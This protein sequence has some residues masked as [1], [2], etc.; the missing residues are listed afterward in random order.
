[1][2]LPARTSR[3]STSKPRSVARPTSPEFLQSL[4]YILPAAGSIYL[5]RRVGDG[6][7]VTL[8]VWATEMNV[9]MNG[10]TGAGKTTTAQELDF[11]APF[12]DMA[13][14]ALDFIGTGHHG[15]RTH[16]AFLGTLLFNLEETF[17][18]ILAGATQWFLRRFAFGA[19]SWRGNNAIRID[20]LKRRR[21]PDGTLETVQEVVDRCLNVFSMRYE[22]DMNLRVRFRKTAK[23]ILAI[24]VASGR[25]ITEWSTL[26]EKGNVNYF[27]F[28]LRE[29]ETNGL[30]GDEFVQR[31]LVKLKDLWALPP[32]V[33]EA[34][35]ESFTNSMDDYDTGTALGTFFG[36]DETYDPAQAV[37]GN[38]RLFLTTD[39]PN[40]TH[41]KEAF[42]AVH[43]IN[44]ALFT[45]RRPGTGSYGLLHYVLDEADKW[46]PRSIL[47][48][49][50][51]ARNL[52][53]S[54]WLLFQ[55]MAQW[56]SAG[57]K[58]MADIRE[59]VCSLNADYR[60][61]TQSQAKE[62]YLRTHEIDPMGELHRLLTHSTSSSNT[63]TETIA[64]SWQDAISE[65]SA[66]SGNEGAS[67]SE[68]MNEDGETC[69]RSQGARQGSG[70]SATHGNSA[71]FGGSRGSSFASTV[72]KAISETIIR[73]PF[74]ERL[75]VGAQ[76]LLRRPD[77]Q[78]TWAYGGQA[79]EVDMDPP[80]KFPEDIDGVPILECYQQWHDAYWTRQATARPAFNPTITLVTAS[81]PPT[82][83][84]PT[85]STPPPTKGDARTETNATASTK[86]RGPSPE[87]S[88]ERITE[89]S[90]TSALRIVATIR[91]C[92]IQ[93]VIALLGWGYD[94][95]SRELQQLVKIAAVEQIRAF[96]P[97]GEGSVPLIFILTTTGA[98]ILAEK[99][100]AGDDLQRI[101]KNLAVFRRTIEANRPA[102][103]EHRLWSST[104]AAFLIRSL[105]DSSNATVTDVRFDRELSIPMNLSTYAIPERERL[106]IGIDIAKAVYVPDFS[107]VA[108]RKRDGKD[109][110]DIV[111]GEIE[112][113]FGE[114]DARDLGAAKA[115]KMRAITSEFSKT[116]TVGGTIYDSGSELRIVVWNRT[117]ALEERFFQGA[118]SVFGDLRSPLWI[119]NGELVPLSPPSGTQKT[120]RAAAVVS[121]VGNIQARVWRWLRFP[122]PA[123]RRRFVGTGGDK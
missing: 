51:Q 105:S 25:G 31:Q 94:K 26:L 11:V 61:T 111:F 78:A 52:Q 34:R 75:A 93:H 97:R 112:T 70:W 113:G 19:I 9:A 50:A 7:P 8:P 80:R 62:L 33:F 39:L 13:L 44:S 84:S 59:S 119:T 89:D 79:V 49:M 109:V 65:A 47:T 76:G 38:G 118:K 96:A 56:G 64:D 77:H 45:L 6:A 16:K 18:E 28:V 35:T 54:T 46:V 66:L 4:R 121:L 98:R 101:A 10:K 71:S 42:L 27:A 123:D 40:E 32:T 29:I 122:D 48:H 67:T 53:I 55:N 74:E 83:R 58:E 117:A 41:R 91:L 3:P 88:R 114:R 103:T 86:A 95:A 116:R 17:P 102:Q 36:S 120:H 14:M 12:D 63:T 1:M 23:I 15:A 20:I 73:I 81:D 110:R 57:I 87:L 30:A 22:S 69:G 115:W 85:P 60:P 2:F 104:L 24:L 21:R 43:A 37:F 107:F 68:T 72:G 106:L 92:T 99:G 5:G 100:G 90:Q 82:E 108:H